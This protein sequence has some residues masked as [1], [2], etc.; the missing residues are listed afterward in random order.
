MCTLLVNKIVSKHVYI[1]LTFNSIY[2][3]MKTIEQ[4]DLGNIAVIE[5]YLTNNMTYSEKRKFLHKLRVNQDLKHDFDMV[6]EAYKGDLPIQLLQSEIEN[7]NSVNISKKASLA[8][9]I[10]G[11]GLVALLSACA[12]LVVCGLIAVFVA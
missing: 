1:K 12:L 2:E 8:K 5:R 7:N 11:L 3:L 10:V 4:L 6:L 9:D